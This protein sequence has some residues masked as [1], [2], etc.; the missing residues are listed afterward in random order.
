LV[1]RRPELGEGEAGQRLADFAA[2]ASGPDLIWEE[3]KSS[4]RPNEVNF[5]EVMG[6]RGVG[7]VMI[8]ASGQPAPAVRE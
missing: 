6:I 4:E 5:M 1:E 8:L 7:G 3:K 2:I